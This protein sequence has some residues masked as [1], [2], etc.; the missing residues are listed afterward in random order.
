MGKTKKTVKSD[1][2]NRGRKRE[3]SPKKNVPITLNMRPARDFP[4]TKPVV[5]MPTGNKPPNSSSTPTPTGINSTLSYDN[6]NYK[7]TDISPP[8]FLLQHE[9]NDHTA[10]TEQHPERAQINALPSD[11]HLDNRA[12]IAGLGPSWHAKQATLE[13]DG[14]GELYP[15]R[16]NFPDPHLLPNT[17]VDDRVN[18]T[19]PDHAGHAKQALPDE[20]A[21]GGVHPTHQKIFSVTRNLSDTFVGDKVNAASRDPAGHATQAQPEGSVAGGRH[22]TPQEKSSDIRQKINSI[23]DNHINSVE[24][25]PTG[26][27][28]LVTPEKGGV[29]GSNLTNTH[30]DTCQPSEM[31]TDHR[32]MNVFPGQPKPM[33]RAHSLN[34]DHS[35]STPSQTYGGTEIRVVAEVYPQPHP[36]KSEQLREA[37]KLAAVRSI[38]SADNV[39]GWDDLDPDN[40]EVAD[41]TEVTATGNESHNSD[42]LGR[43]QNELAK[44]DKPTYSSIA[45]MSLPK[46]TK[47]KGAQKALAD[48]QGA[49]PDKVLHIFGGQTKKLPISFDTFQILN[50]KMA[51]MIFGTVKDKSLGRVSCGRPFYENNG[52]FVVYPCSND[53]S[54]QWIKTN[55]LTIDISG[56]KFRAW[57]PS[58]EPETTSLTTWLA[59][60]YSEIEVDPDN[61]KESFSHYNPAAPDDF[62]VTKIKD[63]PERKGRLVAVEAGP[64]FSAYMQAV[65]YKLDY[66]FG[67]LEFRLAVEPAVNPRPKKKPQGNP[68]DPKA[69][70]DGKR[71]R[72]PER[73]EPEGHRRTDKDPGDWHLAQSRKRKR[74]AGPDLG[75]GRSH[76]SNTKRHSTKATKKPDNKA[77][78]THQKHPDNKSSKKPR[79]RSSTRS[80]SSSSGSDTDSTESGDSDGSEHNDSKDDSDN[81]DY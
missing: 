17:L 79:Q 3:T 47:D 39:G 71:D 8:T 57:G 30:F 60:A 38:T 46:N 14:A 6:V 4:Q 26:L 59:D 76:H 65:N 11:N 16:N 22:L 10:S 13:G 5:P 42:N 37:E 28:T 50:R 64:D 41:E 54:L 69:H 32:E 12:N 55:I 15:T 77:V 58:E 24:P 20:G 33:V 2:D 62:S 36:S 7:T 75:S 43:S 73:H 68:K 25:V 66:I 23:F 67:N 1:D 53:H 9:G 51:A 80:R 70:P 19:G 44:H 49:D 45:K 63:F 78:K 40:I 31:S 29:K 72:P 48:C 52:G 34:I 61:L 18:S 81:D 27:A 56:Q 21:A 74:V 35:Y